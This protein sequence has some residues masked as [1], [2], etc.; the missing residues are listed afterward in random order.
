MPFLSNL[1]TVG[2]RGE[3]E[4]RL[5][6]DLIYEHERYGRIV[7]VKGFITDFASV[8]VF[9]SRLVPRVGILRDAAVIHDWIYRGGENKRF[10]R[11]QADQIF[12]D[13]MKDLGV[14]WWRRKLA[15]WGVRVGGGAAWQN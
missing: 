12:L 6:S 10:S 15:Y 11:K 2:V 4:F 7:A 9:F 8:P 1:E 13:A 5:L 14:P 3:H